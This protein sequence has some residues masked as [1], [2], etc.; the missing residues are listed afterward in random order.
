MEWH[1]SVITSII[2]F[3][4]LQLKDTFD[5]A[6]CICLR[7]RIIYNSLCDW[8]KTDFIH[9]YPKSKFYPSVWRVYCLKSRG[10]NK[11]I[12]SFSKLFKR[13]M[14]AE[15]LFWAND[16]LL[17]KPELDSTSVTFRLNVLSDSW[18]W[19][20]STA[21]NVVWKKHRDTLQRLLNLNLCLRPFY[22]TWDR[23]VGGGRSMG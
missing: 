19:P 3:T 2:Y 12:T 10:F 6:R 9:L 21:Q 8:D 13:L 22:A 17:W 18:L 16:E 4:T 15:L 5:C 20:W 23:G 11:S 14:S 7:S 1:V